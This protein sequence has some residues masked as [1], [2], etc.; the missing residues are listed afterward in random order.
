[1]RK[2]SY[3][4]PPPLENLRPHNAFLSRFT[5]VPGQSSSAVIFDHL[6]I[7]EDNNLNKL[8]VES[9]RELIMGRFHIVGAVEPAQRLQHER[10]DQVLTDLGFCLISLSADFFNQFNGTSC[11]KMVILR[12]ESGFYI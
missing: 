8:R 11:S 7:W 5:I 10:T 9:N 12:D 1:M 2:L 6:P 4:W 3:L